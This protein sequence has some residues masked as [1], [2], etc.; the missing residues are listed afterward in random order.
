MTNPVGLPI[1][2]PTPNPAAVPGFTD[3]IAGSNGTY[4]GNAGLRPGDRTRRPRRAELSKVIT[5]A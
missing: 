2:V 3:I 4:T 5:K 1:T